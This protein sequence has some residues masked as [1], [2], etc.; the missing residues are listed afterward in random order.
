MLTEKNLY[1][2]N[3]RVISNR[4][5]QLN[6]GTVQLQIVSKCIKEVNQLN[7]R[8]FILTNLYATQLNTIRNLV[9]LIA[10]PEL[11]LQHLEMLKNE[12]SMNYINHKKENASLYRQIMFE[13]L[14]S[15][16]MSET[17]GIFEIFESIVGSSLNGFFHEG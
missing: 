14:S 5:T 2:Y 15:S 9:D 11:N 7:H 4:A 16:S 3:I 1:Q 8:S 10:L 6:L 12:R 17:L 13:I